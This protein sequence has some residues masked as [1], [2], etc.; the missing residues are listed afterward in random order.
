[1]GILNTPYSMMAHHIPPEQTGVTGIR[2]RH[3]ERQ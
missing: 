3:L 1:L 2:A